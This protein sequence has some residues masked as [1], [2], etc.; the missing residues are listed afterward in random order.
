MN[1][2]VP[3]SKISGKDLQFQK[4]RDTRKVLEDLKK[5]KSAIDHFS[6]WLYGELDIPINKR[7]RFVANVLNS[8]VPA[9]FHDYLPPPLAEFIAEESHASYFMESHLRE[10]VNNVMGIVKN[11]AASARHEEEQLDRILEELASA[12]KENWDAKE[13]QDKII[14]LVNEGA[15]RE[16]EKISIDAEINELLDEKSSL[17]S[18]EEKEKERAA[19]LRRWQANTV[20]RKKLVEAHGKVCM[21]SLETLQAGLFQ[22]L[23]FVT[24]IRPMRVLESAA[25]GLAKMDKSIYAAKD[26]VFKMAQLSAATLGLVADATARVDVYAISGRDTAE[27]FDEV[28]N[29]IQTK[30]AALEATK[31]KILAL[32]E[33]RQKIEE[34]IE[35]AVVVEAKTA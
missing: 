21:L 29:H 18:P 24:A 22:Y 31:N 16:E 27:L 14:E 34:K 26:V 7:R 17:L 15:A 11:L 30:L 3:I 12:E 35:D 5:C 23:D 32:E 20:A 10:N 13:I 6:D 1:N 9:W 33:K 8:L 4:D 28:N 19:L 25:S 2:V